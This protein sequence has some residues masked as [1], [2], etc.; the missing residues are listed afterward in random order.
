MSSLPTQPYE[1]ADFSGGLTEN[2]I[3]GGK[4]RY[5]VADNFL[6]TVD[7]KL[8][9]RY[10]SLILDSVNYRLPSGNSPVNALVPHD[11][12]S[13]LLGV[14]CPNVYALYPNWTNILGPTGNPPLTGGNYQNQISWG[15]WNH[16]TLLT[17]DSLASTPIKIFRGAPY[18]I[19]MTSPT[20]Q[21]SPQVPPTTLSS[22][23]AVTAGLPQMVGSPNISSGV[24]L[25]NC[26]LLAN[27]IRANFLLHIADYG[28]IGNNLHQALD[29][30]AQGGVA[31][32]ATTQATLITLVTSLIKAFQEH[33]G[34]VIYG[35]G[36]PTWHFTLPADLSL[37][38]NLNN[39]NAPT[40][41]A[42]CASTLD[43]LKTKFLCHELSTGTHDEHSY[44][45]IIGKYLV[46]TP[47]IGS[48]VTGPVLTPS[49]TQSILLANSVRA[50][51]NAH[52]AD[53]GYHIV[54]DTQDVVS[55]PAAV[56][57][58]SL[59]VLIA[60][61]KYQ[62]T[63]HEADSEL[64]HNLTYA[65]TM[66]T[67]Q[68]ISSIVT[69]VGSVPYTPSLDMTVWDSVGT[70]W[71]QSI[72]P[73]V[74]IGVGAGTATASENA[75]S[76]QTTYPLDFTTARYHVA[77]N[78]QILLENISIGSSRYNPDA[79]NLSNW[80]S[81]LTQMITAYNSHD[82][83]A[84]VH[85]SAGQHTVTLSAPTIASYAYAI[86]YFYQYMLYNGV[87][88]NVV[89]TPIF[90]GPVQSEAI[91]PAYTAVD[92][93]HPGPVSVAATAL[94][95]SNI[96]SL[97]N[98]GQNNYDTA[99]VQIKIFRTI[100]AGSTYYQAGLLSHGVASFTDTL[101][102]VLNSSNPSLVPLN[103]QQVIYTSGGVVNFDPAPVCKYLTL[104]N[105]VA[106]YAAIVDTG[107]TFLNRVRQS[108]P[109]T[110][111]SSPGSFFLDMPDILMGVS[112]TRNNV[113]AFCANSTYLLAGLFTQ[114]GS[115]QMSYQS[116]SDTI[117]CVSA[118][119]I[120]RTDVGI[121]FAG[122]DGFYYTDGY[123]LIKLSSELNLTYASL[124]STPSQC[125]K[126]Y[127]TYDRFNR[128][129][130]WSTQPD[131]S[132]FSASQSYIFHVNFG[133]TAN[134][135]FTTCSNG[136]YYR[137]SSMI[138][139]QGQHIRGDARGYLF[140]H[141]VLTKTDPQI[142]ISAAPSTWNTS[143]I[144]YNY[145]SCSIDFG[146]TFNRKW[147]TRVSLQGKNVGNVGA[148]IISTSDN[149][150]VPPGPLSPIWFH[151]N[152]IW[153]QPNNVWGASN[154]SQ[155]IVWGD[156]REMDAWRRFPATQLRSDF[157]QISIQPVKLGIYRYQDWP[158]GAG[159]VVAVQ[160]AGITWVRVLTPSSYTAISWPL[161]VVGY[162][163]AQQFDGYTAE[164]PITGL[165]TQTI[166]NDTLIVS[167]PS[168]ALT[169]T[170]AA[171]WVIRGIL[172]QQRIS[173]T[174][175]NI[176]FTL[177]GKMQSA[178]HGSQDSGENDSTQFF[179]TNYITGE[180]AG[181]LETEG[182]DPIIIE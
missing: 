34:D 103:Q 102:D 38:F 71:A 76:S 122:T 78:N 87:I 65:T 119:S 180:D 13:Y 121:F 182:G 133:V 35:S 126:I 64:A 143:Y 159:A 84:V 137:P 66:S 22:F 155:P 70:V 59:Y 120:V 89:G 136:E 131:P 56:D 144:P 124:V 8:E 106:Y 95:V 7:K 156:S 94:S 10:G 175:Y 109:N 53:T 23:M 86:H 142:N 27:D 134:G 130:W 45:P 163:F 151:K 128:R 146:T 141:T 110:V 114:Q 1:V 77:Q 17:N 97:Q 37:N 30:V 171:A 145:T 98:G 166:T 36:T 42:Q 15:E 150:R 57:L 75:L 51:Y 93:F 67:S 172:K 138:F 111:D 129:V 79:A 6:L 24:L 48:V 19:Q 52:I 99:N 92:P 2:F 32:T 117:G 25:Q 153:G 125:L 176:H 149:G 168:G 132:D 147:T 72:Q 43:E 21:A 160:G 41:V 108:I 61:L 177:L 46:T 118:A 127:G 157:K 20:M 115:G 158:K 50:L 181:V 101:P 29:T 165:S 140:T 167:D 135:V 58:D 12:Q 31:A 96:P 152:W 107:Q 5:M 47:H 73:V 162:V 39:T 9:E 90:L 170:V 174:S 11:N 54:S 148:E 82:G 40:T 69:R 26:I 44:Y 60:H 81:V 18:P 104:L 105:N 28:S 88:F 113:I 161:D 55:V 178:Y 4:T 154:A 100:N 62:Y 169:A 179:N 123:Q 63:Q 85:L 80:L 112:N 91:S 74:T 49:Y 14:A 16:H 68:S 33:V 164:Y 173:I 139:W 83:D 3:G 116:I